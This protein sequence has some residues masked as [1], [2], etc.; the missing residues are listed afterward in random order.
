MLVE[1]PPD[2]VGDEE[3]VADVGLEAI[4]PVAS[5]SDAASTCGYRR[6]ANMKMVIDVFWA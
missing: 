1:M 3:G 6:I 5:A 2:S 4:A